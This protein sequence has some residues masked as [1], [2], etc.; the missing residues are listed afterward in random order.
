MSEFEIKVTELEEGGKSFDLP[1]DPAWL[2]RALDTPDLRAASDAQ[3]RL[4]FFAALSGT[5]VVVRGHVRTAVIAPC[6]RCLAD[7][8]IEVDA[9]LTA[10]FSKKTAESRPLPGELELTP[11]DLDREVYVGDTISLDEIVR[12]QVVLEVPM[13]VHCSDQCPGLSV[14]EHVRGP[15]SL[16]AGPTVDGKPIDPRLAPLL[17]LQKDVVETSSEPEPAPSSPRSGN[18]RAV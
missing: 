10:L 8:R 18:K 16:A 15:S 13:Q 7:T 6:A 4:T 14:P 5:D 17:A 2:D 11:E 3:G 1:V 9:E 12:E